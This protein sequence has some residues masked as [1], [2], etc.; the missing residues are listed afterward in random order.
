METLSNALQA[1]LGAG[2]PGAAVVILS[3]VVFYL[4]KDGKDERAVHKRELEELTKAHKEEIEKLQAINRELHAARL[5]D[6]RENTAARL[7]DNES[8]NKQMLE[9]VKQSTDAMK[10]TAA[11][12]DAHKDVTVEH[13]EAAKQA[14]EE[15]R[16]LSALVHNFSEEIKFRIR[17]GGR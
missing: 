2:I 5:N 7:S 12:L 13:R 9:V 6:I 16:K 14:A 8:L 11:A 4:W 10:S 3:F 15:L 17:P 1:L